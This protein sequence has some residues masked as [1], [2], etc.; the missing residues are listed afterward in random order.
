MYRTDT[1]CKN[2]LSNYWF[3]QNGTSTCKTITFWLSVRLTA[4]T[5]YS[6][7]NR[8]TINSS[9]E[10][11]LLRNLLIQEKS[12]KS[13]NYIPQYLENLLQSS[14]QISWKMGNKG[15]YIGTD[16][17]VAVALL[18]T[19]WVAMITLMLLAQQQTRPG[20][21][22]ELFPVRSR[23]S[24]SQTRFFCQMTSDPCGEDR[25]VSLS[26]YTCAWACALLTYC[27]R[28]KLYVFV[29]RRLLRLGV[30]LNTPH[31]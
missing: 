5:A 27:L 4:Y 21:Q 1:S 23:L 13:Q 25:N 9:C 20:I 26:M 19:V 30:F 7:G 16:D 14:F 28:N 11:I 15:L 3:T 12:H 17:A 10:L 22:T 31:S 2:Y 8:H 6:T 24:A 18:S 29:Q